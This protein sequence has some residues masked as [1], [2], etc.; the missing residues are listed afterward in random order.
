MARNRFQ[1]F[2]YTKFPAHPSNL[3]FRATTA[4][5]TAIRSGSFPA[6][7]VTN[8]RPKCR[9]T[10]YATTLYVKIVTV[11]IRF[12]NQKLRIKM[13][14]TVTNTF[15]QRKKTKGGVDVVEK[16]ANEGAVGE[17]KIC[18]HPKTAKCRPLDLRDLPT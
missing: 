12:L 2:T 1:I 17:V 3:N 9:A 6:Y 5:M 4:K 18:T 16:D 10:H 7:S 14:T 13:K 15:Q 11:R 8:T